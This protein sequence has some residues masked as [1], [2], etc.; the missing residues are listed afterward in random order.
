MLPRRAEAAVARLIRY[1]G[2]VVDS[3]NV[4]LE[5][6]YDLT[7]RLYDAQSAGA[8]VWEEKQTAVPLS[9][10]HFSV[11]IGQV[12]ALS[13]INWSTS[14]WLSVQ[15]GTD[16]ELSP[17]QSITPVP[18]AVMAEQLTGPI[19]TLGSRIGVGTTT[20]NS[21]LQLATA[22]F[23]VATFHSTS[24]EGTRIR[25]SNSNNSPN[26][27]FGFNTGDTGGAIDKLQ[28][29]RFYTNDLASGAGVFMTV[30]ADGK[31]G[32]GTNNPS[33]ILAVQP[34]SASDPIADSW[35]V[36]PSDRKHK[37]LLG[38]INAAAGAHLAQVRDVQLYEWN[39]LPQATDE[40]GILALGKEKP[41]A[42][43]L[44]K[45]KR[46][47]ALAKAA[48]PKFTATRV[49]MAID[50][51][52]VPRE[53]LLLD[54]EGNPAGIDLLAYVGYLHAALKEAA[55]KIDEVERRLNAMS[56]P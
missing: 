19:N 34:S 6:P 28:I 38:S 20:P 15:V 2:H 29:G 17:R 48:L 14:L 26:T 45:A 56:R 54:E 49:G 41:T 3:Q 12:A 9:G 43:E 5:G 36:Y 44:S 37:R 18:T 55:V 32:I 30:Q 40:E 50:D 31:V 21:A 33:A 53:M 24:P 46:D 22:D 39:R 13:A 10:G 51:P 52:N 47:I 23:A 27:A 1:Q 35:T 42:E 7:F 11:L 25:I 4:P 8:K 16:P